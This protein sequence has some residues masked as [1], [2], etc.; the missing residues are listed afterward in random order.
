MLALFGAVSCDDISAEPTATP[1]FVVMP[2]AGGEAT[3]K[4]LRMMVENFAQNGLTKA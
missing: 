2:A 3:A 4:V 1:S